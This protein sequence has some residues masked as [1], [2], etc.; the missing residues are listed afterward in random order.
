MTYMSSSVFHT[1]VDAQ[2]LRLEQFIRITN[3]IVRNPA[4]HETSSVVHTLLMASILKMA[5]AGEAVRVLANSCSVEEI[6]AIG[7]TM[8]E[9][10][11]NA[12]FLQHAS[13]KEVESY[14]HFRPETRVQTSTQNGA[15]P[16]ALQRFRDK[17]R[18][19]SKDNNKEEIPAWS[20]MSLRER[21]QFADEASNIPVMSLLVARCSTRGQAAV[22]GSVGSLD[23]FVAALTN[24]SEAQPENRLAGLTEALFGVN[25]CLFT[26]S[27]YLSSYFDLRLDRVIEQAVNVQ[28]PLLGD[29]RSNGLR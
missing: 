13:E 24:P 20:R 11:V 1:N 25:L 17:F 4:L 3:D 8:L 19:S 2:V 7:H 16:S 23:Y 29:A 5:S 27:F 15:P 10:V 26:F 14:L 9:I 21:A 6:L 12:A 18:W 22:R 28:S